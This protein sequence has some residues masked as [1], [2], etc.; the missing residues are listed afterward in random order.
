MLLKDKP[1]PVLCDSE[2]CTA[3]SA[4]AN[5]C[6]HNAIKMTEDNHGELHPVILSDNCIRCGLCEKVC[7]EL[8]GNAPLK[9]EKPDVYC[10]WLKSAE[11]RKESTSGGAG[12][13]IACAIIKMGG[14]VWGAAYDEN[15]TVR[16]TE[17]NTIED[18]RIIQKSK[19]VQSIV[20]DSFSQI[21]NELEKGDMVLFTGTPCHVKGLRSYLRKDYSNLITVDL[22]CHG[23]PGHGVFRKYKE[24]LE[25]KYNDKMFFFDFRPKEKD[26]QER[27]YRSKAYFKNIGI[28]NIELAENGYIHG[29]QKNIFLREACF[30]C[31][32]KGEYRYSDITLADFW[33]IGKVAPF[34]NNKERPY[35]ISM[36]AL[37]SKKGKAFLL[38]IQK[39]L[40]MQKR[41]YH[42]ASFCNTQYYKS[43]KPSLSRD[44]FWRDWN[45]FDWEQLNSMYL[46]YNRKEKILYYLKKITPPICYSMLNYWNNGRKKIIWKK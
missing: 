20:G 8:N 45:S 4:C 25:H 24:W 18:L 33:G 32:S 14:H 16:Y 38:H 28:K 40:F 1:L 44:A 11:N 17:A 35:G 30:K 23:V 26:G 10:C 21:K 42:E 29:Y 22:V 3:C 36:L 2:H 12:Y 37:N 9:Y 6:K 7:P 27:T 34:K 31:S 43:S 41:S 39:Y 46:Q 13:A 19:Y 15:M 5:I